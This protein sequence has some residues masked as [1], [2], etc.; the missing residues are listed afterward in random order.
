MLPVD[1]PLVGRDALETLAAAGGDVAVPQTGPL[2]GVYRRS[3]LEALETRLAAG[4]LA[5]RDALGAL[6]TRVVMIEAD[7]LANVNTP[8]DLSRL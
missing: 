7:R 6:D 3:A 5:L 8:D 1:T 2:P 4:A